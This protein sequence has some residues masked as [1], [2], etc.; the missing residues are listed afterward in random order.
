VQ[1]REESYRLYSCRGCGVSVSICGRCDRGNIYC[2][3]ECSAV[4]RRAS[5]RRAG[6]RYQR[7][8]RG[9]RRHAARQQTWRE[10]QIDKVTHQGCAP[11]GP[12]FTMSI[13]VISTVIELNDAASA[14]DMS[15]T[16]PLKAEHRHQ[17]VAGRCDFCHAPL[18][19]FT[20]LRT[21]RGWGFG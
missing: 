15:L 5:N 11:A 13:A 10:R 14:P 3:G 6:A 7:T 1:V 8:R 4:S 2:V 19:L 17:R 20:R 16:A 12:V 9:A 18:P 21:W